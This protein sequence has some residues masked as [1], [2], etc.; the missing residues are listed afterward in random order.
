MN[1]FFKWLGI[2][3]F[4]VVIGFSMAGCDLLFGNDYEKLNGVWDRGDIVVTFINN[5]AVF[6]EIRSNSGNWLTS[7]ESGVI[8][9]GDQKLKN[10]TKTGNLEWSC[11]ELINPDGGYYTKWKNDSTITMAAN[12]QTLQITNPDISYPSIIYVRR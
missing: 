10:I 2:I 9:I 6:T 1:N 5:T 3:A 4:V 8:H 7:L 11:Q 12:G